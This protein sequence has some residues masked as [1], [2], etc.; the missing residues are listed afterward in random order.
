[1]SKLNQIIAVVAGKKA[2]ATRLL[3]ESHR[4]WNKDAISGIS[5]I[6]APKAEDGDKLPPESKTIHLDVPSK[7]RETMAQIADFW[8][9]VITQDTGNTKARASVEVGG[10]VFLK[11]L[12]VTCLLFLEKQMVDLHTFVNNLPVLPP[13]REW[14][15]DGNR[16]CHVT[17]PIGTIRT[18]KVPKVIVKYEPTKEHPAQTELIT[19]DET[20]G[21]WSTTYMSS[22]IPGQE[23]AAMLSRIEALQDGIK[24]AREAANSAEVTQIRMAEHVLQHIFGEMLKKQ[25]EG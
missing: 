16:N 12:P 6:Y 11:D 15:W 17:D 23:K 14:K 3:T 18:Q 10:K 13:D 21:T 22:A 5:K 7:V 8:D 9:V 24:A 4:G 19:Q 1:M 2:R 20:V 25:N